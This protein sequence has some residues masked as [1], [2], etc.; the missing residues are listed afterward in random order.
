MFYTYAHYKA[1]TGEIFYIG[2]GKGKR[3]TYKYAR[4]NPHWQNVVNK[5]GFTSEILAHWDTEEEAFEHEKLLISCFR[6]MGVKLTNLTD[7]G[8]GCAGLVFTELHKARLSASKMGKKHSEET[9]KKMSE[10][11]KGHKRNLGR[12]L[13]EE[14]KKKLSEIQSRIKTNLGKKFSEETR[15]KMSLA[16]LRKRE[17]KDI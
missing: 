12:K 3:Y 17:I 4:K 16:K 5:Y 1:G 10:S 15:K 7:G 2:K 14:T 6:D 13:S 9:K 11:A 8:D